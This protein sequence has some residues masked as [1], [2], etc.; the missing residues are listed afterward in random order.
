MNNSTIQGLTKQEETLFWDLINKILAQKLLPEASSTSTEK[1]FQLN[2]KVDENDSIDVNSIQL[3][4]EAIKPPSP[5]IP[6]VLYVI[7]F[8]GFILG[9]V[10]T[11]G[12]IIWILTNSVTFTIF[13]LTGWVLICCFL[14][15]R[16]LMGKNSWGITIGACTAYLIALLLVSLLEKLLFL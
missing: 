16:A 2:L 15:V 13:A 3:K 9:F 1:Q 8:G 6:I 10:A 4:L 11:P 7:S 5:F 14:G 12:I